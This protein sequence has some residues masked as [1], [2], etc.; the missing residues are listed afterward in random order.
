[1]ALGSQVTLGGLLGFGLAAGFV[2]ALGGLLGFGLAAGF[3]LAL[4]ELLGS[5]VALGGLPGFGL[6]AGFGLVLGSQVALGGLLGSQVA[7]GGL[8]GFGLVLG[9]VLGL[10]CATFRWAFSAG[11]VSYRVLLSLVFNSCTFGHR[12]F[13]PFLSRHFFTPRFFDTC[14]SSPCSLV[15][16]VGDT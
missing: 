16:G 2:L 14:F 12:F 10:L 5:Q 15:Y 11:V 1:L 13:L 8:P 9:L 4:G 3:V 7:L 6:A